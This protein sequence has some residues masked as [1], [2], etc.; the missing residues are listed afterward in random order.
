MKLFRVFILTVINYSIIF[1]QTGTTDN[2]RYVPSL[3]RDLH[4][5]EKFKT[6]PITKSPG[7]YTKK[8]WQ[9]LIDSV[10]GPGLPTSEK[11]AIFDSAFNQIDWW[12][13]AFMNLD[14]D[15]DSLRDLYRPEIQNGVSR[16]RFAA[17]MNYF[18]MALKDAHTMIID[19]PVNWGTYPQPGI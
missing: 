7:H 2:W 19:I 13:G 4:P 5:Y 12:Y 1:S 16:G 18:S 17:I 11:L 14:V 9:A 3:K 15:I 10:W 6:P 8:D